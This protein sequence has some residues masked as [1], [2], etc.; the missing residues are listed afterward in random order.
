MAKSDSFFIRADIRDVNPFTQT[1]IDLGAYVDALG[2]SVLRIHNIQ[3]QYVFGNFNNP[4]LGSANTEACA[5][6]QLTTQSQTAMQL[7]TNKSLIS[8][9]SFLASTQASGSSVTFAS[10]KMDMNPQHWTQATWLVLNRSILLVPLAPTLKCHL[11][12]VWSWNALLKHFHSLEQWP[13]HS[14]NNEV[15]D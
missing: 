15:L 3:V 6:W 10:E 9:G 13:L 11:L 14:H 1:A 8:S 4:T 12:F 2:K 5:R 7:A